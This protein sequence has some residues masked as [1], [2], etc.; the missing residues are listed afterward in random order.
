MADENTFTV[1][2]HFQGKDPSVRALYDQLLAMLR[3]FGPVVEEP[4]KTSIHLVRKSALAGV[5]T[6]RDYILLNI[7]AN[8]PIESPR[9]E[10]LERVSANRIHHRVRLSSPA[11]LN[12][13]LRGWLEGAYALSS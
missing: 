3:T 2:D 9:V 13:E 4:K 7:K 6:R 5:E 1:S 8:H 10:K 11:D 12:D